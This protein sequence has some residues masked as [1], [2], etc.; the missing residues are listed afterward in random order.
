[1]RRVPSPTDTCAILVVQMVRV[2]G[3]SCRRSFGG[4]EEVG[5]PS[6]DSFGVSIAF[7]GVGGVAFRL[8]ERAKRSKSSILVFVL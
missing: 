6:A 7:A 5:F 8:D 1:M 3:I 4:P 2:V